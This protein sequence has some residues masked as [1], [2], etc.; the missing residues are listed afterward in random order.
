MVSNPVGYKSRYRLYEQF[1]HH[2]K[3]FDVSLT[4]VEVIFGDRAPAVTPSQNHYTFRSWDEL[5][6]K[7]NALNLA[8]ARLPDDWNYV[9]WLDADIAFSNPYWVNQT[10]NA[11]QHHMVVQTWSDCAD[12]GPNGEI[13]QTHKSLAGLYSSGAPMKI[14]STYG[15][16]SYAHPGFGWAA[17][18][19]AIDHMGGLIDWSGVGSGDHHMALALIGN[20][21][22]SLPGGI[23][24]AYTR[25]AFDF[26]ARCE[27]YIR[28]DL[29]V[30]P[31]TILHHFHGRKKDRGYENRWKILSHNQYNPDTDIKYGAN[32]VLQLVDHGDHRSIKL[33][34]DIRRYFRSRN[35]DSIDAE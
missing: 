31:G 5:W 18:R 29:G 14:T 21:G 32:G 3:G 35:E 1:L 17:R 10:I 34:D 9:A 6:L 4:T 28:R 33:R 13:F 11:L 15:Q 19:E 23:T 25:R 2:M 26:Q 27:K 7:E 8:I 30:V 22:L 20:V 12:L 24:S 16:G